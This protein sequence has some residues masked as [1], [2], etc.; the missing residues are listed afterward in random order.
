MMK[1]FI[2]IGLVPFL[3]SGLAN[4]SSVSI[5]LSGVTSGTFIDGVGG[6]L[7]KPLMGKPYLAP[8]LLV[9]QQVS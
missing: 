7:R 6:I 9:R 4:A 8:A 1:K 2:L 3:F 5:D